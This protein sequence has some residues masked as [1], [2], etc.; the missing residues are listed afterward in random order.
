MGEGD[1][2]C[3]CGFGGKQGYH[4]ILRHAAYSVSFTPLSTHRANAPCHVKDVFNSIAFTSS[5]KRLET[6]GFN[7]DGRGGPSLGPRGY[8]LLQGMKT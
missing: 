7:E 8:P 6:A 4:R 1:T 3:C 5:E 2:G